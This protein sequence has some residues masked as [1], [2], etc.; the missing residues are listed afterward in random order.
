MP[1]RLRVIQFIVQSLTL[2]PQSIERIMSLRHETAV[3]SPH[4]PSSMN[5]CYKK[6]EEAMFHIHYFVAVNPCHSGLIRL[7]SRLSRCSLIVDLLPGT[8]GRKTFL[9][10]LTAVSISH[11]FFFFFFWSLSLPSTTISI[12]LNHFPLRFHFEPLIQFPS[13]NAKTFPNN[14]NGLPERRPWMLQL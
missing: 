5:I 7:F 14:Q 8:A 3:I 2:R 9:P 6:T 13:C 1:R 10:A 12:L 4:H 11:F